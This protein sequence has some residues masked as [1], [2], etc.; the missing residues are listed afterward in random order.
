MREVIFRF[1]PL[2]RFLEINERNKH[3]TQL[4]KI[5]GS[6][7]ELIREIDQKIKSEISRQKRKNS[8]KFLVSNWLL[9]GIIIFIAVAFFSCKNTNT[10]NTPKTNRNVVVDT[11]LEIRRAPSKWKNKHLRTGDS[12]YNS[13]F[14][15]GVYDKYYSNKI[16]LHNG[17]NTDVIACLTQYYRPNKTI[18]NEYIIAGES[19]EMT[20]IPNGVYYLKTFYGKYWNPDTLFMGKVRGLFDTLAGFSKSDEYDDLIKLEQNNR[21]YSIYEITLYP[22]VGGNME[23]EP[24]NASEFFK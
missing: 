21:Q 24:I 1:I 6:N 9:G 18:R 22:V 19:F 7:N 3:T 12:P 23:S 5:A 4:V 16:I 8:A 11:E 2:I 17:Q 10:S 14:G 20:N 13:Y 15:K